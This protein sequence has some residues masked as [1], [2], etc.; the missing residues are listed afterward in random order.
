MRHHFRKVMIVLT[1]LLDRFSIV[2][3]SR[4]ITT[5]LIHIRKMILHL[6]ET[7]NGI[8]FIFRIRLQLNLTVVSNHSSQK[9][10]MLRWMHFRTSYLD[11]REQHHRCPLAIPCHGRVQIESDIERFMA[12]NR[13]TF[14]RPSVVK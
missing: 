12:L 7:S 10:D 11:R 6:N 1:V 5:G 4:R 8:R 14:V 9:V 3:R 13:I 2:T